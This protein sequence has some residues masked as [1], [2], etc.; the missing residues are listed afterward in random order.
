MHQKLMDQLDVCKEQELTIINLT[1][2]P[3]Q[4]P[5]DF[6]TFNQHSFG[7]GTKENIVPNQHDSE[8]SHHY[9]TE[10]LQA[11]LEAMRNKVLVEITQK[12]QLKEQIRE[13]NGQHQK[14]M[15]RLKE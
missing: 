10:L 4:P 15:H 1:Q 11:D 13:I 6:D 14:E 9:K 8:Q 2:Q 12:N 5:T 7:Q 3:Q